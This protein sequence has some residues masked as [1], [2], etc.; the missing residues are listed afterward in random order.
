MVVVRGCRR[1][2]RPAQLAV[3]DHA[4]VGD[5]QPCA[6]MAAR[7][8]VWTSVA[9]SGSAPRRVGRCRSRD[10]AR[11]ERGATGVEVDADEDV[12]LRHIGADVPGGHVVVLALDGEEPPETSP[13]WKRATVSALVRDTTT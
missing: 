6:F 10:A 11:V 2:R 7:T 1:E 3:V 8:S 4:E 9:A 5:P 13:D 12:G